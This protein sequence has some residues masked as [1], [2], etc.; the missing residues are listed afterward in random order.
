MLPK[1]HVTPNATAWLTVTVSCT[2]VQTAS[3]CKNVTRDDGVL[4]PVHSYD[5]KYQGEFSSVSEITLKYTTHVKT[6]T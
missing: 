3:D 6:R 1:V 4:G 5:V 2:K